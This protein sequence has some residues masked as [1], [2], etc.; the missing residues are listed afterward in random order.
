M[1]FMSTFLTIFN[2]NFKMI[3]CPGMYSLND[4]IITPHLL[5]SRECIHTD[6][7]HNR[8]KK[9][10]YKSHTKKTIDISQTMYIIPVATQQTVK[11]EIYKNR[12]FSVPMLF[13]YFCGAFKLRII[14]QINSSNLFLQSLFMSICF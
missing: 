5:H 6:D 14:F 4:V 10:Y 2:N 7:T 3:E 9:S 11:C 12:A 8:K 1:K 13:I